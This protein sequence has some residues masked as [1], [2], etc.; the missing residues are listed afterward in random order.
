[1]IGTLTDLANTLRIPGG[2][3]DEDEPAG[4]LALE[5]ATGAVRDETRQW[6]EL[7]EDDT[8]TVSTRSGTDLLLPELP[9]VAVTTVTVD[10]T[11]LVEDTDYELDLGDDGRRGIIRRLGGYAWPGK[12]TV[13]Y[14]HGY[15]TI[16]PGLRAVVL[17][18]AAR[19]MS[20]PLGLNQE[21]AG[22]WMGGYGTPGAE[23]NAA[24]RIALEPY[25]A[26]RRS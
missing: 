15:A 25:G 10:G 14:T 4:T 12:V 23:L 22:R 13:T 11:D 8:I 9:V 2:F 19:G 21:T 6:L 3:D 16:P 17:R 1:M 5:S 18:V 24:D 26:G 20:N 7:V